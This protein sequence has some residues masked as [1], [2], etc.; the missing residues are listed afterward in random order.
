MN[1]PFIVISDYTPEEREKLIR[2]LKETFP[3]I[4]IKLSDTVEITNE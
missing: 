2:V 3:D 1:Y 4:L